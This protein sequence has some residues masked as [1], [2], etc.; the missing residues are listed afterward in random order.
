MS[1]QSK[2][3]DAGKDGVPEEV[4]FKAEDR[5]NE[6]IMG[7]ENPKRGKSWYQQTIWHS[8]S[9]QSTDK[10]ANDILHAGKAVMV[11][12]GCSTE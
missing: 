6:E 10:M 12:S 1:W 7:M 9:L 3:K 5:K 8:I 2:P 4:T 11:I